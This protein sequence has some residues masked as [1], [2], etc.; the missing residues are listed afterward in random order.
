[1]LKDINNYCFREKKLMMLG[2]FLYIFIWQIPS[3]QVLVTLFKTISQTI[4]KTQFFFF[5]L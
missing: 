5:V 2:N 3:L 4:N 1:M